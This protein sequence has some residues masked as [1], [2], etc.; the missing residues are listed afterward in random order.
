M[1]V[2]RNKTDPRP[3]N[4]KKKIQY[5]NYCQTDKIIHY[6]VISFIRGYQRPNGRFIGHKTG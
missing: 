3:Y 6:Q 5:N 4:L 1:V 2:K